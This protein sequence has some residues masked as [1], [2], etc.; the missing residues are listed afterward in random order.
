MMLES[1]T[2]V[3]QHYK[4]DNYC[5]ITMGKMVETDELMVVYK[6]LFGQVWIRPHEEFFGEENKG[7][8]RFTP[9][10]DIRWQ[11][12]LDDHYNSGK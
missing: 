7:Q 6:N 1:S 2:N 4:G 5:V 11:D 9:R 10:E 8:R 12:L 3:Y